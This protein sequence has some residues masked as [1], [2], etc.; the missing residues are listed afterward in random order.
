M[1][2]NKSPAYD[3]NSFFCLL[4]TLQWF[5]ITTIL[6]VIG[7]EYANYLTCEICTL[8]DSTKIQLFICLF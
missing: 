2:I 3:H 5:T 1:Y 4:V 7:D 6:L 8:D